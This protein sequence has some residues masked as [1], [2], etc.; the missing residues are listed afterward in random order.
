MEENK[1]FINENEEVVEVE[2]SDIRPNPDQPRTVFNEKKLKELAQSIKEHGILQPV[3]LKKASQGYIVVAGERRV[4]ASELA[5]LK[6]VPAIIRNYNSKYLSELSILENVQREDLT[7]IEQA[8]AF[9]KAIAN[10]KLTHK[11]LGEKIGKSRVYVTNIIGLL[12]LPN[13]VLDAVNLGELS[14]GHARALSKLDN[15]QMIQKFFSKILAENLTVRDIEK[16]IRNMTNSKSTAILSEEQLIKKRKQIKFL[17]KEDYKFSLTKNKLS[18][19]FDNE[20]ELNK[21][22]KLLRRD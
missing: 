10:L 13:N 19:K 17:L 14:M 15:Q 20:E 6:K 7:P 16:I 3:I 5:N 11:E 22:I 18:L 12:H 21:I 1:E 9:Q 4:R 2:I 8:I